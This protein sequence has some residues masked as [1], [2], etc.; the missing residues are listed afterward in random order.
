MY[1]DRKNRQHGHQDCRPPLEE[2]TYN[3]LSLDGE[4]MK[5]NRNFMMTKFKVVV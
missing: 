4:N 2:R 1:F 5:G 3:V